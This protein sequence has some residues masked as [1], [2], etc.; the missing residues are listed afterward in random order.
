VRPGARLPIFTW[1]CPGLGHTGVV[2][3]GCQRL[4]GGLLAGDL[5]HGIVEATPSHPQATS[6]PC[7]WEGVATHKPPTSQVHSSYKP[8]ASQEIGRC[9]EATS[10]PAQR[11]AEIGPPPFFPRQSNAGLS[12]AVLSGLNCRGGGGEAGRPP[13]YPSLLVPCPLPRQARRLSVIV[14]PDRD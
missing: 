14:E 4:P 8:G 3:L 6:K 1:N 2:R 7:G 10:S 9:S 5:A 11:T 13:A 12:D